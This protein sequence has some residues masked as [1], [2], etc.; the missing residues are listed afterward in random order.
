MGG[1]VLLSVVV[2]VVFVVFVFV[3]VILGAV[4]AWICSFKFTLM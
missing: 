2:V 3:F 4:D 1:F